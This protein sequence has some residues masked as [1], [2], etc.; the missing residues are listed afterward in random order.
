MHIWPNEVFMVAILDLPKKLTL[1][2][3]IFLDLVCYSRDHS[4]LKTI[5]N[6][7]VAICGG[8]FSILTGLCSLDLIL[9]L[10]C[11]GGGIFCLHCMLFPTFLEK[12]NSGNKKKIF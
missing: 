8:S 4:G 6:P 9:Y 11:G 5:E 2:A 12:N 10:K 3:Y 1:P 7:S